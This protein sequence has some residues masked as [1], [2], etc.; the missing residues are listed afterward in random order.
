M[1]EFEIRCHDCGAL[2]QVQD[3]LTFRAECPK[4]AAD[5]HVCLACKH[6]DQYAAD[7][8]R[9]DEAEYVARKDRR[10][11][12]EYFKP[13]PVGD[14]PTTEADLAKAKLAALFGDGPP[15]AD[16]PSEADAAKA[17]LAAL[18]EKK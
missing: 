10:N 18:F 12:C 4:C 13:L 5:L 15:P 17:K 2:E 14:A 16:G 1:A 6:Y 11:L 7:E 8:C 3:F 9:V